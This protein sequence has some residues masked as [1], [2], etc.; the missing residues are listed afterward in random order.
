MFII[1]ARADPFHANSTETRIWRQTTQIFM[2]TT[3]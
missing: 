1:P 2:L 3:Q